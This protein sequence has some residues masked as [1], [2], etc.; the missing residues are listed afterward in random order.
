M[1]AINDLSD[2]SAVEKEEATDLLINEQGKEIREDSKK[3]TN[4]HRENI[5]R[6][7]K[8]L[9]DDD[10]IKVRVSLQPC[11]VNDNLKV[12][13]TPLTKFRPETPYGVKKVTC[14]IFPES[15]LCG[16]PII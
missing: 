10:D 15:E 9:T 4:A 16:F 3:N 13:I 1:A 8:I 2:I 14:K 7:S 12:H 11:K 5:R 6:G